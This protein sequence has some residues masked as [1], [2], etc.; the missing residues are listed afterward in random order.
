MQ[1]Y[2]LY[3]KRN[4]KMQSIQESYLQFQALGPL[5]IAMLAI[6]LSGVCCCLPGHIRNP[7]F[8]KQYEKDNEI[9]K[10]I[11][12]WTLASSFLD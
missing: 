4:S 1:C 10:Y 11:I 6:T 8:S 3:K 5:T 12:R 2:Y 9:S 7:M